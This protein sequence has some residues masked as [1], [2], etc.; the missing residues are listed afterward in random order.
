MADNCSE[1]SL[2]DAKYKCGWCPRL[3]RCSIEKYCEDGGDDSWLKEADF[4]PDPE[5]LDFT[6][7][8]GLLEGGTNV[9]ITGLNLGRR[10]DDIFGKITVAGVP[11]VPHR[12]SYV[13]TRQVP[14]KYDKIYPLPCICSFLE[15]VYNMVMYSMVM[16]MAFFCLVSHFCT[17]MSLIRPQVTCT[18]DSPGVSDQ[19][20]GTVGVQLGPYRTESKELFEFVSPVLYSVHPQKGPRSGGTLITI[21]GR[22][23][24][25]ASMVTVTIN[26]LPCNITS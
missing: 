20:K 5:I 21:M 15:Y 12:E 3:G 4:C 2:L 19:H 9:T 11:C 24:N 18:L 25:V 13:Q 7:K 1:C 23:M 26:H 6:P 14:S 22:H 8:Y 17:M 10:F 16:G